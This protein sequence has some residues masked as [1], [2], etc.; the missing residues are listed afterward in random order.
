VNEWDAA[1]YERVADPQA[2]WAREIV[3]RSGIRADELVLDAGCGGGRVTQQL[4]E[5]TPHVIAVDGDPGMVRE[6]RAKLPESVSVLQQDLLEL[7]LD[8]PVDVVFSCAVF[9]WITD[10]DRL[11][12]RLHAALKPG[13]RLVAQCGGKG[14][15]ARVLEVSGGRSG[16]WLFAGPEETERRLRSA[17]FRAVRTWLEPKP[18]RPEDME[19]FL[20]TVVFHLDPDPRATAARVAPQIDAVDYVRLNI[21]AVKA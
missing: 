16:R 20:A 21:E 19:A 15:I 2:E 9:H 17:G 7:D 18:A 8:D 6:A 4:L 14:N 13:G 5:R 10:H 12:E 11:F 1:T 3:A